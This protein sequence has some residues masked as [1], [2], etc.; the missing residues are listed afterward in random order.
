MILWMEIHRPPLA[1]GEARVQEM[2]WTIH[3]V[4]TEETFNELAP[5]GY[6]DRVPN[7]FHANL[8]YKEFQLHKANAMLK[9]SK[10]T[11]NL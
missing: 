3:P 7:F 11:Q 1:I 9:I 6:I 2:L 10:N 4:I 8:P 5:P